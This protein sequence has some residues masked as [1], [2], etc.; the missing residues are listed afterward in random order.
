MYVVGDV[1]MLIV[2]ACQVAFLLHAPHTPHDYGACVHARACQPA[3]RVTVGN[4][5]SWLQDM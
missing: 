1:D 5:M 2:F 4:E 3:S